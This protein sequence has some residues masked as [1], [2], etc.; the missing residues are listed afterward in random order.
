[1]WNTKRRK[2]KPNS[3]SSEDR[4]LGHKKDMLIKIHYKAFAEFTKTMDKIKNST[5]FKERTFNESTN[6]HTQLIV[7]EVLVTIHEEGITTVK[8][9]C[10]NK[11]C[12]FIVIVCGITNYNVIEHENKYKRHTYIHTY[13]H[14]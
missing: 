2:R 9:N 11:H 8:Y 6:S 10:K 5:H 14:A 7:F 3:S 13:M 1:M 12:K 4:Q